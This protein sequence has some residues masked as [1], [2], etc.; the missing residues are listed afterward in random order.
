MRSLLPI[1]FLVAACVPL[2][3]ENAN[4]FLSGNASPELFAS[5]S[6]RCDALG[7]QMRESDGSGGLGA[8]AA[9]NRGY[10]SCM[11]SKGYVRRRLPPQ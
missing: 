3:N 6:A 4:D 9:F 11:M 8:I 7:A 1:F 2:R 5:D 10:D